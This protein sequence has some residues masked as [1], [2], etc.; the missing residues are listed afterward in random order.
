M[1]VKLDDVL[2]SQCAPKVLLLTKAPFTRFRAGQIFVR[3]KTC[4]VPPCVY[5]GS[6]ELDGFLKGQVWRSVTDKIFKTRSYNIKRA[7]VERD[8]FI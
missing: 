4:T 6:A 3:T 5:T 2:K 1:H 7:Q 8:S